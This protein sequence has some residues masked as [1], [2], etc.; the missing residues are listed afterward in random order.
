MHSFSISTDEREK[1][2]AW[3]L[4]VAL[5]VAFLWGLLLTIVKL[6]WW[7]E[8]PAAV[9]IFGLVYWAYE[10]WFWRYKISGFRLSGTP[11]LNGTWYGQLRSSYKGRDGQPVLRD[12][13]LQIQQT[14]TKIHVRLE[15]E[16]S[17]SESKAAA[18]YCAGESFQLEYTYHNQPQV[19]QAV[20]MNAH[21]GCVQLQLSPKQDSL[22]GGYFTGRGRSTEGTLVFE[23]VS[24]ELLSLK[25]AR[26]KAEE[27]KAQEQPQPS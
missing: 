6:P 8:S 24:E 16:S 2:R 10:K 4:T 9:G 11:N 20:T 3:L 5:G 17:A 21:M 27:L 25:D 7:V 26:T 1:I 18:L 12:C 23:R 19:L 14:W 13:M 22:L 15:T